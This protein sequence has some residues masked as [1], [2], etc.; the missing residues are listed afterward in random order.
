MAYLII[1][2]VEGHNHRAKSPI[3]PGDVDSDKTVQVCW[4]HIQ[5]LQA[6]RDSEQTM[7]V[8]IVPDGQNK[9]VTT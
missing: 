5:R 2:N 7:G 9:K 6:W 3:V 1:F 4:I 8:V